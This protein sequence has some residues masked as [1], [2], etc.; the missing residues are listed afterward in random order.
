M[1]FG[2]PSLAQARQHPWW[3]L[4][5]PDTWDLLNQSLQRRLIKAR[6]H[7]PGGTRVVILLLF[8]LSLASKLF[9]VPAFLP[10]WHHHL[11]T[12]TARLVGSSSRLGEGSL[13]IIIIKYGH[14]RVVSVEH[15]SSFWD[16]SSEA[17][18]FKILTELSS[19][20]EIMAEGQKWV[21]QDTGVRQIW[22]RCSCFDAEC[23]DKWL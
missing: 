5:L 17:P 1:H 19:F 7:I 13:E 23:F 12:T 9:R 10:A 16:D 21:E 2:V 3:E 18:N 6:A 11:G 20:W 4:H 22:L 8:Y 14:L 15:I